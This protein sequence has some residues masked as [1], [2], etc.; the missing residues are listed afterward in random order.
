M[1]TQDHYQ[2]RES[3]AISSRSERAA[4]DNYVRPGQIQPK[5]MGF[6]GKR[7]AALIVGAV[8]AG[9]I[10]APFLP[11]GD[12]ERNP[13]FVVGAEAVN[14]NEVEGLQLNE[15]N[16]ILEQADIP[17]ITVDHSELD[18]YPAIEEDDLEIGLIADDVRISGEEAHVTAGYHPVDIIN[19]LD[20]EGQRWNEV[21][22][23]LTEAG[24]ENHVDYVVYT[25]TGDIYVESNWAVDYVDLDDNDNARIVVTN[26][27]METLRNN[28][29]EASES[30]SDSFSE[31]SDSLSE[32]WNEASNDR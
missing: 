21:E 10:V 4:V 23:I 18:E 20:I 29:S 16:R 1:S 3:G 2:S 13:S 12:D 31:L 17:Q 9:S 5:K 7:K 19:S 32:S 24:L 25:D 28:T 26:E 27:G 6:S 22:P 30:L 8:I 15:V 11:G 14:A